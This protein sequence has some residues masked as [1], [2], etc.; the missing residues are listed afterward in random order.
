MNT[1]AIAGAAT[2]LD[3]VLGY[4]VAYYLARRRTWVADLLQVSLHSALRRPV[5]GLRFHADA[6]AERLP[7][8]RCCG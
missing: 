8:L 4:P 5:R 7:E 2:V 3:L 1:L 6:L